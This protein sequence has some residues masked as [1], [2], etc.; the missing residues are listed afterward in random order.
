MFK[1]IFSVLVALILAGGA[2]SI[3]SKNIHVNL[4]EQVAHAEDDEDDEDEHNED[5]ED[6]EDEEEDEDDEDEHKSSSTTSSSKSSSSKPKEKTVVVEEPV[7]QVVTVIEAG[8]D[9][10]T[11]GD[12]LVDA[13]DPDP[14]VKQS[15]YFTDDDN[16]GIP[17]A[18]DE[19]KGED[20]FLYKYDS[21]QNANGILDSYE[22]L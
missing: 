16:D 18:F 2:F 22:N 19:H 5:H 10:D 7:Y 9:I 14:L 6:H 17:N 15:E 3:F 13:I 21:D 1:K 8:Y 20:D 4:L 11:D 12:R